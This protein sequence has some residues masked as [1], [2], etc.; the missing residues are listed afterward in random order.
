M[1]KS[2]VEVLLDYDK[3]NKSIINSF[4]PK[5]HLSNVIFDNDE[6]IKDDV[7]KQLIS[8][9]DNFLEFLGVKFF[10]HDI[11]LT[12]SLAS[13]G[14]SDYSDVD[15][16]IIFDFDESEY[17][18]DLLIE[19]FNAKKNSWNEVHNVKIKNYD[20]EIYI[21]DIK[22]EHITSGIYSILNNKWVKKPNSKKIEIDEKKIIEKSQMFMKKID[23]LIS[24]FKKGGDIKDEVKKVK[25]KIKNFRKS[26]LTNDGEFSYE[27]LTFKYLRRNGYMN[28]LIDL[29]R[30]IIDKE[31]S[32]KQ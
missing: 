30:K 7:R 21:Q 23:E 4:Y 12:G 27:N 20:V 10:V 6:K 16:H 3:V 24:K 26:G 14:W 19:F 1:E 9:S 25:N 29:N 28:K 2:L 31:L 13:Y 18:N 8:I 22:E 17:N 15:L 5:S 11:V 32:I